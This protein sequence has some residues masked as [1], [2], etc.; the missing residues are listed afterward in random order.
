M[1]ALQLTEEENIQKFQ[2]SRNVT[3]LTDFILTGRP[4]PTSWGFPSFLLN[5]SAMLTNFF[6]ESYQFYAPLPEEKK[7]EMISW[8]ET[9]GEYLVQLLKTTGYEEWD[10]YSQVPFDL[11]YFKQENPSLYEKVVEAVVEKAYAD[12]GEKVVKVI[13]EKFLEAPEVF[14]EEVNRNR[15]AHLE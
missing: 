8:Y 10:G 4:M 3:L 5:N 1:S 12:L 14:E 11:A 9:S 6:G 13:K 15:E 2:E 7:Q